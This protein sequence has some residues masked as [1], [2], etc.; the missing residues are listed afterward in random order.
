MKKTLITLLAVGLLAGAL[1]GST[2]ADAA[3]RRTIRK[4]SANYDG[5][6][7]GAF[8]VGACFPG[9]L[10]CFEFPLARGEKYIKVNVKDNAGT[11]VLFSVTQDFNG[12]NQADT[13]TDYCTTTKKFVRVRPGYSVTIFIWEGPHVAPVCPGVATQGTIKVTF[14]NLPR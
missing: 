13:G 14:S 6:S 4:M 2:P 1:A 12:D 3:R 5:P 9:T 10:G 8:G 11:P 7:I